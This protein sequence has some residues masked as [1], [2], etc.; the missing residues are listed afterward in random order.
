MSIATS[1]EEQP[2]VAPVF[3]A[4]DKLFNFYFI[5][6]KDAL[7]CLHIEQNS[8]VAISIYN[9][10]EPPEIVDGVQIAGFAEMLT[11]RNLKQAIEIVYRKRFPDPEERARHSKST[12]D[13]LNISRRRLFQVTPTHIYTLDLSVAESDSR[14]EVD[15]ESLRRY[16]AG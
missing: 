5:S 7:H 9:S 8:K 15:L 13:F 10:Q 16:Q 3:Y 2:W 11:S 6:A 12:E 1:L 4:T 14:I